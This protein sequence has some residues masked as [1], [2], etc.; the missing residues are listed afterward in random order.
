MP[1][2]ITPD[3]HPLDTMLA[4]SDVI[5]NRRH[6]RVYARV[7]ELQTATVEEIAQDLDSSATTIYEDVNRLREMGI[8]ERLTDSQPY[9]Y[10]A[11]QLELTV[12]ADDDTY[13]ITPTFIVALAR[14]ETNENIQLFLDRHGT[15]GLA[16]AVEYAREY[17]RGGMTARVMAR[18][19][20]MPVLEA[21][22]ILQELR[23]V[24]LDIEPEI[25]GVADIEALDAAVDAQE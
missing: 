23:E 18:E 22:T 19:Q 5:E 24:I 4:I 6:A 21:E 16:T 14:S 12:H 2:V 3:G 11:R 8:L 17:V 9:R 25:E 13:E 20:E 15:A 1:G 7:L 10:R